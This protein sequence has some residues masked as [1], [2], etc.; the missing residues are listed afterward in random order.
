MNGGKFFHRLSVQDQH[1]AELSAA[2]I[3]VSDQHPVAFLGVLGAG[4]GG[5][6]GRYVTGLQLVFG[7]AAAGVTLRV[8]R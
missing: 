5:E 6:L 1:V 2:V 4:H 7:G 8:R 3:L